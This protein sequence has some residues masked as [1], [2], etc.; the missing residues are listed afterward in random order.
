MILLKIFQ[1][2]L[3]LTSDPNACA[4]Q[5]VDFDSGP[6]IVVDWMLF[7]FIGEA[8]KPILRLL[9][10]IPKEERKEMANRILDCAEYFTTGGRA[11]KL[12]IHE[13]DESLDA[14][15]EGID[16]GALIFVIAHEYA[17]VILGH[18]NPADVTRGELGFVKYHKSWEQEFAADLKGFELTRECL[19][20]LEKELRGRSISNLPC[21]SPLILMSIV[22]LL[23]KFLRLENGSWSHPPAADRRE[24]LHHLISPML[25]EHA[26]G[27][28]TWFERVVN[29]PWEDVERN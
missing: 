12:E 19:L 14:M 7:T 11:G 27:V 26:S 10:R 20:N 6:V 17:H 22:R 28:A 8:V 16:M 3:S 18:L 5:P 2:E 24:H 29:E 13:Y 9:D 23:E 25:S 4:I 1:S 15:A 21:A